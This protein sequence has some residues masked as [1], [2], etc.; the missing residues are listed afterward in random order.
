MI[1]RLA[2]LYLIRAEAEA[3]GA[4]G[5][6]TSAIGDLNII[7]NR[8]GL[9]NYTG[10]TDQQSVLTAIYHERQVE[11]FTEGHRWYDLKRTK[12]VD[13]VMSIATALKGGAWSS[14]QQL[15]PLN[16]SDMQYDPNLIQ[17]A[18]Y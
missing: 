11:L 7:R 14:Y 5:G 2:E 8:A 6:V 3:N 12:T 9:L 10:A 1:F 15:Y 4:T 17:N 18:G 16:P 13:A